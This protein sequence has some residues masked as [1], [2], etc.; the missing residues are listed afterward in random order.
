MQPTAHFPVPY[1]GPAGRRRTLHGKR[2]DEDVNVTGGFKERF[3]RV[4]SYPWPLRLALARA[5]LRRVPLF[6]Y[7]DRLSIGAVMWPYYGYCI[8]HAARLATALGY[9]RISVIEFGCGGGNG[10]VAAERHIAEIARLF[11]IEIELYGFDTGAG[12]PPP[13]DYRDMPHYFQGGLYRMDRRALEQKLTRAA[14]VIGDVKETCRRF[15]AEHGAAPVGCMLHDLDYYSSTRDALALFDAG[16]AHFLPR[17]FIYF[18]DVIGDETWL[19][20]DYAGERLAITEFN[21]DHADQKIAPIPSLPIQFPSRW[22]HQVYIR[23]DFAHP[24]YNDFV[25]AAQ[26]RS[27][28]DAIQLR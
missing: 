19:C 24:R 27:H 23:H 15:F 7:A 3:L 21:R 4:V 11:P 25:G 16:P 10:L 2:K 26:Q 17:V 18:D 12:L 8:Y 22:A 1:R 20:N 28:Q 9:P 14:L 13:R 5:V 6:S